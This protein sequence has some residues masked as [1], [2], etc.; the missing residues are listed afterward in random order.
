MTAC[1]VK[2][3]GEKRKKNRKGATC[4]TQRRMWIPA[5]GR[6]SHEPATI[7][8]LASGTTKNK[9]RTHQPQR[10]GGSCVTHWL[11]LLW[12]REHGMELRNKK[13]CPVPVGM[14][15]R[16]RPN[17]G[18]YHECS[19]C[20]SLYCRAC[21]E[22]IYDCSDVAGRF[23]YFF[24]FFL[25]QLPSSLEICKSLQGYRLR[26]HSLVVFREFLL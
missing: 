1:T 22:Q 7:S 20:S 19:S 9:R 14:S 26:F 2:R 15:G 10:V 3:K 6:E 5:R 17:T 13:K 23:L 12:D 16:S 8:C 4:V 25:H 21:E 11:V 18:N 24:L